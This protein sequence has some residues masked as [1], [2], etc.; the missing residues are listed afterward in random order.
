MRHLAWGALAGLLW[1]AP[2]AAQSTF[3]PRAESP[4]EFFAVASELFFVDPV[5]LRRE[6]PALYELLSG[7]YRQDPASSAG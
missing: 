4:E 1:V 5:A 7:Y 3:T 2:A 6:H